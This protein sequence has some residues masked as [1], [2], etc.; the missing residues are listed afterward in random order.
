[1]MSKQVNAYTSMD[2]LCYMKIGPDDYNVASCIVFLEAT[3]FRLDK[4]FSKAS[5]RLLHSSLVSTKSLHSFVDLAGFEV[6]SAKSLR[7]YSLEV[8][9]L[10]S[11]SVEFR[12]KNS[13][14]T[15]PTGR[16]YNVKIYLWI[17]GI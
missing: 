2:A 5:L 11:A 13:C 1:M 6:E 8:E 3:C 17:R 12:I 14:L 16:K 10:S 7:C 4:A 15:L 9:C